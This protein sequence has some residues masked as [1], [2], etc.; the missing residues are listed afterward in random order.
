MEISVG[1]VGMVPTDKVIVTED[2][3]REVMGDLDA[4][5]LNMKE[6]GLISPLAVKD[7]KDGTF[8]LLAG[9]RRFTVLSRNNILNIPARIY[10]EELSELEMKVI[11]KS[12]NF[13]RKD[14][15]YYELDKLT[16]EIHALQQSIHG[17]TAPGPGSSGWTVE[18]TGEMVGLTKGP[19]SQAIKR[20][21]LREAC[22][23]LFEGCKTASDATAVI[24][25]M[26]EALLKQVIAKQLE[27]KKDDKQLMKLASSFII[28]SFFDGVKEIPAGVFHLVEIDPPYSIKLMDAKRSEGESQYQQTD[29]N[30]V[31]ADDYSDFLFT[32]FKE[33]YRVM[34]D[35]SWLICW[36]APEPW[37][38]T[39]YK[40]LKEAGF[41]TTRMCPVWTKPS[42]QTK[43]PE[44]H[45]PNAYE[46]FFYAW[47][48]RPAIARQ[49]GNNIF[50]YSP[51]PPQQKSHPTERPVEL[52]RDLYETFAFPGSRILIPFLGS[53]SGLI[54]AHQVGM[55]AL[56]FE[57]SKGYKDSFLVKVHSMK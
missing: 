16:L 45:L 38:N 40:L 50:N 28:K 3:V 12:E 47:K 44:M 56:G 49:R 55:T 30:E 27:E 14:M 18:N 34:A 42:G 6:S 15:E 37:F 53:G 21:E 2:R 24:K 8:T 54:A 31:P 19:T 41:E 26:D 20:A 22:P 52:M 36:F 25:K 17:V 4:L 10:E 51:V 29:Y 35:H 13:F 32:V 33:S 11:E 7:N 46:M 39:V 43:R 48:G 5:E 9:E 23:E 1:K 57:L